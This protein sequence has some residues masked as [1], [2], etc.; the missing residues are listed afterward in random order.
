MQLSAKVGYARRVAA[1]LRKAGDE[2]E[3]HRIGGTAEDDRNRRGRCLGRDRR[4]GA[5]RGDHGHLSAHQI[6]R[7][8]RQPIVVT[9]GPTI[10]DRHILAFDVSGFA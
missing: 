1:R 7:Q 4:R 3:L 8:C 5:G 9:F 2:A 10:F 6:G